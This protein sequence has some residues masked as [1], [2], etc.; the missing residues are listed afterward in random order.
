MISIIYLFIIVNYSCNYRYKWWTLVN[1][2][3]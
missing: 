2:I 3:W 1:V